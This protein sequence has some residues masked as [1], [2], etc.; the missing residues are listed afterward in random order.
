M[1]IKYVGTITTLTKN[2]FADS[3]FFENGID[4]SLVWFDETEKL[5]KQLHS[6][7]HNT[8][9]VHSEDSRV[10][11][12]LHD[13]AVRQDFDCIEESNEKSFMY[14]GSAS[15]RQMLYYIWDVNENIR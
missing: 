10:S 2:C 13:Y 5:N 11:E 12:K 4:E 3:N 14:V 9:A 15:R 7:D 8:S 6:S 1:V